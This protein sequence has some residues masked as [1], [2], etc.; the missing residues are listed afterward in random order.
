MKLLVPSGAPDQR[1][2]RRGVAGGGDLVV[3]ER[4]A[5]GDVGAGDRERRDR[6]QQGV[7]VGVTGRSRL[8]ARILV[9]AGERYVDVVRPV[10]A[11]QRSR[12]DATMAP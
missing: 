6:G 4:L 1:Q 10:V 8:M 5:V 11:G 12:V 9:T 3:L 2:L 7:G